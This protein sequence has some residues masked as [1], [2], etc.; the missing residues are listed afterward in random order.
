MERA[1]S[2]LTV[3]AVDDD[4]RIIDGIA[5]TPSTDRMGDVVE[6]QGVQFKLPLPL[7][8]QHDSRQPIGHVIEAKVTDE[9]IRIKAQIAKGVLRRIDE[10]WALIKAGLVRGLSI[11]FS[12]IETARIEG[13][14]GYRFLKWEWLELS[15]VTIPAN[16][17]ATITAVKSIDRALLAA[18]G[19][20]GDADDPLPGVSGHSATPTTKGRFYLHPQKGQGMKTIQ[21]Q[22][23]A[24]E[25][26]RVAKTARMSEIMQK[27]IDEG[28]STD[29]QEREEFD[30]LQ[31]EVKTADADLTRLRE[32]ERLNVAAA[33]PV[34][35]KG[36]VDAATAAV[37]RGTGPIQVRSNLP[38]GTAFTRY[39]IALARSHGNIMHAVEI[40]KQ[41][42]DS[43]PEVE[44][45]LKAAV[46]A[47]TT[48]DSTWA[49]PLVSQET[50]ASEFIELL[51]PATIIG[52]IGGFRRVPFNVKMPR[53]TTGGSAS[54]VGQGKAKPVS[55]LA[56]DTVTLG[57]SKVAGIVVLTE[58]L[59][60]FSNPSAEAVVRD[61][62]IATI[63][64]FLDQQ[65]IDPSVA[66]VSNVS[67]ASVTNGVSAVASTG[68]TLAN[69][70]AD[71]KSLFSKLIAANI[72][73]SSGT[74][75]MHPRTALSLSL[76]RTTQEIVAYPQITPQGGSWFGLPV[77]TSAN[78]PV[79]VTTGEPTTITLVNAGDVLLA[80]DGGVTLDASREASLQMD[81]AP[82]SA[83]T[84]MISL[85]QQNMIGLRAERYI[86][87]LK[88]RSAAV[89]YISGVTY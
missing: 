16:Q 63:A 9:G 56:F 57:F 53:Q 15:A 68:A 36:V 32:L 19:T 80:D 87:W 17:D 31:A 77:V 43:T 44:Q 88:R 84:S 25:A 79:G 85:W 29:E 82:T 7:L 66:A 42:R 67:P 1:Y 49:A 89:Q 72:D 75:V 6:P 65:F 73:L 52:R 60:R 81:S 74:W 22:I 39:A 41:W 14:F 26:A 78:V 38:K 71:V 2:L 18:F 54:W 35:P 47:G 5:S 33:K 61:D 30:T 24:L 50:M 20:G 27:S 21:E 11:G 83:A 51:R 37:V 12:A 76:L 58:E 70:E 40:A 46:D 10:A 8:W 55:E 4:Q 69:V 3:K 62:M 86:N 64:Q 59:V 28:R 23:A 45:V 48:T 34:E 13:S